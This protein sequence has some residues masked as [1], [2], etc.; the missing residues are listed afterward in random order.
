MRRSTSATSS[1]PSPTGVHGPLPPVRPIRD[2][3]VAVVGSGP[4]GLTAA[5]HLARGGYPVTV[6]EADTEAGGVLR[7]GIPSYRSA[8]RSAGSRDRPHPNDGVQIETAHPVDR[9]ELE[10]LSREFAAV[11]VATGLKEL[12][13]LDVGAES[14]GSVVQAI[15]FLDCARRDHIDLAGS[16]VVVVGG[17]NT[18]MDAARSALRLGAQDVRV[19]Y[20]RTRAEMPAIAEEI[21]E[22]IE[23]GIRIDELLAPVCLRQANGGTKL[24]CRRMALGEPDETGRRRPVQ[25]EGDE[26]VVSVD[27]DRLLLALG[28]SPDLSILPNAS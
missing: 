8:A 24:E 17:G 19:V 26:A 2:E 5:Y 18:A 4:A 7:T 12:R 11:F 25:V 9:A 3:K 1:A 27:C 22:A 20:R 14:N 21:D 6:F 16:K 13:D 23:E 10:R 15:E 28:Q